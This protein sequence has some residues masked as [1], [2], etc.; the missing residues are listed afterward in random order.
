MSYLKDIDKYVSLIQM[1]LKR[2]ICA[3]VFVDKYQRLWEKDC[4]EEHMLY[5]I[6]A[7]ELKIER[8]PYSLED[9]LKIRGKYYL[10]EGFREESEYEF[11]SIIRS[12]QSQI[13]TAND[14]YWTEEELGVEMNY[15]Y[16][17][18]ID[19]EMLYADVKERFDKMIEALKKVRNEYERG[20]DTQGTN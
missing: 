19:E 3:S 13:Y 8:K 2:E 12:L 4:D 5:E 7:K 16:P 18:V 14:C 17:L 9:L 20:D 15:E 1:F 11:L 10:I 6:A